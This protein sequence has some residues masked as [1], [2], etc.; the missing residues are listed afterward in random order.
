MCAVLCFSQCKCKRWSHNQWIFT[1]SLGHADDLRSVAPNSVSLKKQAE[2][3]KS[4]SLKNSLT[5][6]QI[7]YSQCPQ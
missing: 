2:M 3:V 7:H 1:G 6:T 5:L 4:R